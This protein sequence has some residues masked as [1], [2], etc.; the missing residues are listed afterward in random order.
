MEEHP[1]DDQPDPPEPAE[2]TEPAGEED[3][4]SDAPGETGT[5]SREGDPEHGK[6][7]RR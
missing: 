2:A 7:Y 5:G 6:P 3:E 1:R 4:H